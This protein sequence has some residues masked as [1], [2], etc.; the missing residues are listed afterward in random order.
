[1]SEND[2]EFGEFQ[3]APS[4]ITL[5][6]LKKDYEALK[7]DLQDQV[8]FLQDKVDY[9]RRSGADK[10]IAAFNE[11]TA[12]PGGGISA[13]VRAAYLQTEGE[14]LNARDKLL[15]DSKRDKEA[16]EEFNKSENSSIN[17]YKTAFKS[18]N[19]SVV[20]KVGES[21]FPDFSVNSSSADNKG[22][23]PLSTIDEEIEPIPDNENQLQGFG[24]VRFEK[25]MIAGIDGAFSIFGSPART[26]TQADGIKVTVP[27]TGLYDK[28]PATRPF[29]I[30]MAVGFFKGVG[31]LA[32]SSVQN[33]IKLAVVA[34]YKVPM[35]VVHA[36]QAVGYGLAA[37]GRGAMML[38]N[39]PGVRLG[40]EESKAN[41]QEKL[42]ANWKAFKGNLSL[43]ASH[44]KETAIAVGV[45]G[46]AAAAGAF[47]AGTAGVGAV[48]LG[49]AGPVL[50]YIIGAGHA[51]AGLGA[52]GVKAGVHVATQGHQAVAQHTA[53]SVGKAVALAGEGAVI[54]GST[55]LANKMSKNLT[56]SSKNS[57]AASIPYAKVTHVDG[58]TI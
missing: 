50:P 37:M 31:Q 18:R 22:Y 51:A 12:F 21:K 10:E 39:L 34:A 9:L 53:Q 17:I 6:S 40:N 2:E 30:R 23:S 52:A 27:A 4:P 28:Q 11:F 57:N 8:A 43:A 49:V 33:T 44:G 42:D 15:V 45:I 7:G 55:A 47:I 46:V 35:L 19:A 5:N 29:P 16:R 54:L 3:S 41:S 48:G 14:R 20:S 38:A 56:Q 58:K 13:G 24:S 1:M 36:P 32:V 26:Y 25:R